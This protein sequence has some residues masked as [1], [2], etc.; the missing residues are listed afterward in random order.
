MIKEVYTPDDIK[1]LQKIYTTL[2]KRADQRLVTLE[3]AAEKQKYKN[4][5][6]WAYK[7]AMS[8]IYDMF[9][10]FGKPRFNKKINDPYKLNKAISNVR[11]FLEKETSSL[12]RTRD[13]KVGN[14]TIKGVKGIKSV[15]EKRAD[16]LNAYSA[17]RGGSLNISAD[18]LIELT[19]SSQFKKA[20]SK[21]NW[22]DIMVYLSK[23]KKKT[24]D[25][26]AEIAAEKEK[27]NKSDSLEVY[28][29][30]ADR[31]NKEGFTRDFFDKD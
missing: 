3:K 1:D 15:Y 24:D 11:S 30:M 20:Q 17:K 26:L 23:S 18:D 27:E 31:L 9:G 10:P 4:I 5:K 22:S 28:L 13:I 7:G 14:V 8:D 2:A 12:G 19:R 6:S 25:I 21:Y 29:R 16:A